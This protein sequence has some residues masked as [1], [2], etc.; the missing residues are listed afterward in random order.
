MKKIA[1]FFVFILACLIL[2]LG[3]TPLFFVGRVTEIVETQCDQN[4]EA[5]VDFSD[6]S[7]NL[8]RHFPQLTVTLTGLQVTGVDTFRQDTLVRAEKIR[9]VVNLASILTEEGVTI[10]QIDL[11]KPAVNGIVLKDGRANWNITK[12]D[13]SQQTEG[14]T[15]AV[16]IALKKITIE[17]AH[18]VYDDRQSGMVAVIDRWTGTLKGNL[19]SKRTRIE[20]SSL[21]N[22][23]SFQYGGI[24]YVEKLNLD[25]DV[26]VEADF[27][28]SRYELSTNRILLN[29]IPLSFNGY[30]QLPDTSTIRMDV[31]LDAKEVTFKQLL[32]LVPALYK[33]KFKSLRA[34]GDLK[35]SASIKGDWTGDDYPAFNLGVSVKQG[36]INYPGLPASITDVFVDARLNHTP[37]SLDKTT[38]SVNRFHLSMAGQPIDATLHLA[39][40]LSDPAVEASLKG[41]LNL[42]SVKTVYPLEEGQDLKGT[43]HADIQVAGRLSSVEK[44]RYNEIKASGG[45][46]AKA[47]QYKQAEGNPIQIDNAALALTPAAVKLE[48]FNLKWGRND[49]SASGLL[50]N[51]L[52]WLMDKGVLAGQLEIASSYLNLNDLMADVSKQSDTPDAKTSTA[53]SDTSQLTAIDVPTTMNLALKARVGTLT[54]SKLVLEQFNGSLLVKDG[55]IVMDNIKAYSM[56]G[57]MGVNGYYTMVTPEHPLVDLALQLNDVSYGKTANSLSMIQELAPIFNKIQGTYSM[58]LKLNAAMDNHY[59]PLMDKLS[60]Q[61]RLQSNNLKI[62]GVK[63]F[64]LLATTLKQPSLGSWSP[65]N[66]DVAFTVN[67]GRIK[68]SPFTVKVQ[69]VNLLFEGSSGIDK[70][71]NYA[72]KATLPERLAVQGLSVVNGSIVGTFDKPAIKMDMAGLARQAAKGV[73]EKVVKQLTGGTID[74]QVSKAKE[75]LEKQAAELRAQA[76]AA[77]EKLIAEAGKEGDKLIEKAS[78]PVL[79][80]A[81]KTAA[82]RLKT[83]AREEAAALEAAAEEKIKAMYKEQGLKP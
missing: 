45:A 9:L 51:Y 16:S 5:S 22:A 53:E 79:K 54:F 47:I 74:Q 57:T 31:A 65:K 14:D 62:S 4:L 78:N 76:K 71:L 46:S 37:G 10:K 59:K 28:Q 38:F 29:E 19:S 70:T 80:L 64:D 61:G 1:S 36:T 67:D 24:N 73:A 69:D 12:A 81:A 58:N 20:T 30:V 23:V 33:N 68:T 42:A 72:V 52:L 32:S 41:T 7:L 3:I 26:A 17:D 50:E 60:A 55:R 56:G 83:K 8:F 13:T 66:V 27:E 40:P 63:V 48:S 39:T 18:I 75:A 43:L 77:G 82:D 35:L 6:L 21:I 2:L 44:K 11:V 49:L 25:A 15:S 34:S